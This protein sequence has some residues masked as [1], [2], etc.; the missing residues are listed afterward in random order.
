MNGCK[1]R[2]TGS[3]YF[4]HR[5]QFEWEFYWVNWF[6]INSLVTVCWNGSFSFVSFIRLC[7]DFTDEEALK[8]GM[9][10]ICNVYIDL[11]QLAKWKSVFLTCKHFDIFDTYRHIFYSIL[12]WNCSRICLN[13]ADRTRG[14]GLKLRIWKQCRIEEILDYTYRL[15]QERLCCQ[16]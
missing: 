15:T 5:I 14:L 12:I 1:I 8:P 7:C 10:L 16:I 2:L 9:L 4:N 6:L 13:L 3:N 11:N